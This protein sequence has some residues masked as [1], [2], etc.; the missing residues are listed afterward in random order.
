M[1]IG[2]TIYGL[3]SAGRLSQ[4]RLITHLSEHGYLQAAHTTCL[5]INKPNGIAFNLVVD[6]CLVKYKTQQAADR[7]IATLQKLYIITVDT[8]L[9][10]KY[11]GITID[12]N[13]AKGHMDLSMPGYITN[14]LTR[15]NKLD[16]KGAN[17]PIVYT[18]PVYGANLI[19]RLSSC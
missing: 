19:S 13:M 10:Q 1:R 4:D 7:L 18:P 9:K 16:I 5:F 14:A 6:N 11:V 17:S 12:Y 3:T 2:S 15:F 8:A